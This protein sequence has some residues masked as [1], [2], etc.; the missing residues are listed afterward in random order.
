MDV[1]ASRDL[2][3]FGFEAARL[4]PHETKVVL[5]RHN[6]DCVGVALA[7]AP[8]LH[9]DDAVA[10]VDNAQLHTLRNTPLQAT[11]DVLLPGHN[12]EVRLRLRE[13]ERIHTAVEVRILRYT[14]SKR[15]LGLGMNHFSTY[16]GSDRVARHHD[17]RAHWT[18]LG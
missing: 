5:G 7:S 2:L 6:T 4:V 11:V 9:A 14:V 18:V 16:P 8:A 1:N 3:P 12:V 15:Y 10:A 17:N 13:N